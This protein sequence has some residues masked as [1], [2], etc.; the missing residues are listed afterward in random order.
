MKRILSAVAALAL[1]PTLSAQEPPDIHP[2]S[3]VIAEQGLSA[4]EGY[5][6]ME[7]AF[8][9]KDETNFLLGGVRFLRGIEVMM[10]TRWENSDVSIGFI[11]GMRGDL[12]FNPNAKFDPAFLERTLTRGLAEMSRAQ[13]SLKQASED[14]FAVT[15]RITDI[16][17]DVNK[18]GERQDGEAAAEMFDALQPAPPPAV[19]RVDDNG[20]FVPGREWLSHLGYT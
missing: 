19:R 10:Q 16:W 1:A 15:V 14:E 7:S 18:D 12:P 17:F 20:E 8:G 5:L 2:V 13:A 9:S 6:L 4:G 11:P 3:E